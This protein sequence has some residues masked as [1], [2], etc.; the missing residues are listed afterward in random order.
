M[1]H[2]KFYIS[3]NHQEGKK[4]ERKKKRKAL[5]KESLKISK[6]P[7]SVISFVQTTFFRI[8]PAL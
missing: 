2:F 1:K 3:G 4:L 7:C 6:N 5:K 8:L